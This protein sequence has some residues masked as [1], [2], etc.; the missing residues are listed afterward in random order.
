MKR[1]P[2]ALLSF[3]AV[4]SLLSLFSLTVFVSPTSPFARFFLWLFGGAGLAIGCKFLQ[5]APKAFTSLPLWALSLLFAGILALG[6]SFSAYGTAEGLAH[7]PAASLAAFM[8]GL[9]FL[10]YVGMALLTE[11]LQQNRLFCLPPAF[12]FGEKLRGLR[13]RLA[14]SFFDSKSPLRLAAF[15]FLCWLPY[16]VCIFPGTVS[17]DSITQLAEIYGAVPL[18]AGNPLGQTLLLWGFCRIGDWLQSPDIAIALYCLSQGALM[19]L[20]FAYTLR[21][22]ADANSPR[23]LVTF[24]L[25]FFAFNPLFPLFAFCVGKDTNFSMTV[26]FFSLMLWQLLRLPKSAPLPPSLTAGLCLSAVLLVIFRNPGVYLG[27]LVLPLLGA[28][29][30]YH[31]PAESRSKLWLAPLCALLALGLTW[32]G[33]QYGLRPLLNALPMPEAEEYS[34]PLQQIA[35]VVVS[36]PDGLTPAE[37]QAISG[38]LDFSQIKEA[39]QPE[40]SDPVKNLWKEPASP[41]AKATFFTA[42][43]SLLLRYPATCFSATFH[44]TY[45]YVYPGY[46]TAVKPALLI[47]K[48]G[49]TTALDP[50]FTF[51]VNPLSANVSAF[52]NALLAFPLTRIFLAPGLYGW[53]TLFALITVLFSRKRALLLPI[54]PALFALAGCLL[55]AVNGYF[56]YALPLS[57]CAP[58]LLALCACAARQQRSDCL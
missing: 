26:L 49:H 46:V 20:L 24:S 50:Y 51:S 39:Y 43:R 6:Q 17:N 29:L 3:F 55:S 44:N 31:R 41:Q 38:L 45:G 42:W 36:Q 53:L 23:W 22:M 35:R 47:G 7:M 32:S 48:Q 57:V 25:G 14:R 28:Y 13:S 19:A 40:L 58:L 12:P 16:Y 5:K 8:A 27:L 34:L 56:R 10:C 30:F 1:S 9:V 21:V 2:L 54:L 52:T 33:L 15:L 18:S 37:E 4:A 11:G